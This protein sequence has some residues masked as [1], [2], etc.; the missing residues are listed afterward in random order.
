MDTILK[1]PEMVICEQGAEVS[2]NPE[3]DGM[4]FIAKGTCKVVVHDKFSQRQES[5]QVRIID[6]G[7]HFGEISMI[8]GCPRTATVTSIYYLQCA[9]ITRVNYD[10]L[11]LVYP[12]LN[13]LARH[14]IKSYDDPL[15]TF[16]E[17]S[18]N[19]VEYFAQFPKVVKN[20]WIYTMKRET[21]E[22]GKFISEKDE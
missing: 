14:S 17:M 5:H 8:Y 4:Y 9:K 2:K 22:A 20:E 3:Q 16:L 15:K 12:V 21:Y 1:T 11:L 19:N 6:E 7:C 18:L 10:E 13:D